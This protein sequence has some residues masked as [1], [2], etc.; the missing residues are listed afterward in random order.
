MRTLVPSTAIAWEGQTRRQAKQLTHFSFISNRNAL[1]NLA[2]A[3]MGHGSIG[4]GHGN[5]VRGITPCQYPDSHW[6]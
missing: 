5:Y 2:R 6:G 4:L 1:L 3:H